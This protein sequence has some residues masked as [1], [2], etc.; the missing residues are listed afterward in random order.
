VTSK[1]EDQRMPLGATPLPAEATALLRRWIDAGAPE[2]VRQEETHDAPATS[3]TARR[4][5]LDIGLTT[6]AVPPKGLLGPQSP[7][8]LELSL[9]VGP[10]SPVAAVVFSPDGKLLATGSYRQVTIWDV[11]QMRPVK[12]LTNVLGSVNDLRFSPDGRILA[13]AGGQPCTS[14]RSAARRSTSLAAARSQASACE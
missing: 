8:K 4:R 10:L 2:G 7:G 12:T 1:D 6:T 11:T 3:I 5:K 14:S 13:V 9:K